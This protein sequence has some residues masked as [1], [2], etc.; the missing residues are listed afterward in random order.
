[1]S[2]WS[3]FLSFPATGDKTWWRGHPSLVS[4]FLSLVTSRGA[5]LINTGGFKVL[6]S[7]THLLRECVCVCAGTCVWVCVCACQYHLSHRKVNCQVSVGVRA[8]RTGF[9]GSWF[10]LLLSFSPSV[11]SFLTYSASLMLCAN[12][13]SLF[14]SC[15]TEGSVS[16]CLGCLLKNSLYEVLD[17]MKLSVSLFGIQTMSL[18]TICQRKCYK[19]LQVTKSCRQSTYLCYLNQTCNFVIVSR[20]LKITEKQNLTKL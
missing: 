4:H 15:M 8:C 12:I 13:T 7:Q 16:P 14:S 20:V 9:V 6:T 10:L 1:M 2:T 3:V 11:C 18:L 19:T 5:L 17:F